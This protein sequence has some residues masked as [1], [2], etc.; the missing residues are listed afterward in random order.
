MLTVRRGKG[1]HPLQDVID[2]PFL[3]GV[4]SMTTRGRYE[5]DSSEL[6]P[7]SLTAVIDTSIKKGQIVAITDSFFGDTIHGIVS[8]V[9]FRYAD[10]TPSMQLEILRK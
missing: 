3:S 1:D 8:S 7:V 4:E 10:G 6:K 9:E 5:I 2:D